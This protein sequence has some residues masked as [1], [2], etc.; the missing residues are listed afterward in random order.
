MAE[1]VIMPRQGQSVESCIITEWKKKKGEAV[2][3]G[4]ILFSYETDKSAF[5]EKS[6]TD[7]II[8]EVF[9]AEGD[10]VPCL[11]PVCVI[12]K[13][14]EDIS[15]L[16]AGAKKDAGTPAA[17][18]KTA[19]KPVESAPAAAADASAPKPEDG[20]VRISPRARRL[21]EK[22]GADVSAAVPTG[23]MGRII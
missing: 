10:D 4:D 23:P 22:T 2:S 20:F 7:G 8:L 21:A 11:D 18:E 13:E 14:G 16:V 3:T 19:V 12:G 17:E 15:A 1:L 6:P 5:D 9:A